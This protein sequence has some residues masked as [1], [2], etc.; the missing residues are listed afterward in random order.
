M[1]SWRPSGRWAAHDGGDGDPRRT[2]SAI[3][4]V[5]GKVICSTC[6]DQHSQKHPPFDPD[7]P[8]F[9]GAGTGWSATGIGRHFQRAPNETNRMCKVCHSPRNVTSSAQGSHP[10]GVGIPAG[11][12]RS[13]AGLPLSSAANGTWSSA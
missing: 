3:D 6:H 11:N 7:A 5:D 13:P 1:L 10:V 2:N 12:F 4:V 9:G 8:A